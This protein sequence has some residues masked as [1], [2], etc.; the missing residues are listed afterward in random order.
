MKTESVPHPKWLRNYMFATGSCHGPWNSRVVS[1]VWPLLASQ[2]STGQLA[3]DFFNASVGFRQI[4]H[5][6][7]AEILYANVRLWPKQQKNGNTMHL[8]LS[9]SI[10]KIYAGAYFSAN[11]RQNFI[12]PRAGIL[13]G[14]D[15]LAEKLALLHLRLFP[16][17]LQNHP[18]MCSGK[19]GEGTS[20]CRFKSVPNWVIART[21]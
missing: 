8:P 9:C 15:R 11:M 1:L 17:P 19:V 16:R 18:T 6:P 20:E 5:T 7:H 3:M 13:P 12:T 4:I 10:C 14:C 21:D 2:S